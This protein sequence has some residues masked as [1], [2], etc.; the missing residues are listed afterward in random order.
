MT[1]EQKTIHTFK[2]KFGQF[3]QATNDAVDQAAKTAKEK[4]ENMKLKVNLNQAQKE[5]A[6]QFQI[7]GRYNCL[8]KNKTVDV[9][10]IADANEILFKTDSNLDLILSNTVLYNPEGER[11]IKIVK[12]NKEEVINHEISYQEHKQIVQCFRAVYKE[13]ENDADVI[14]ILSEADKA[15][16]PNQERVN[17]QYILELN[18]RLDQFELKLLK[19]KTPVLGNLKAKKKR[20]IELYPHIKEIKLTNQTNHPLLDEFH[21]ILSQLDVKLLQAF[22]DII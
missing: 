14:S 3:A 2:E 13:I 1:T 4:Y 10:D 21:Q 17:A 15:A 22:Y 7:I 16:K 12:V 19:T 9:F 5:A 18:Q 8:Q 6:T 11:Q 20:A